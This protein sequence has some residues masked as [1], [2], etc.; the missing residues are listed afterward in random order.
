MNDIKWCICGQRATELHHIVFRSQCKPLEHCKLNQ[1]YLCQEHHR[2]TKGIHGKR[3]HKLDIKLKLEFQN[4]LEMLLDKQYLTR[5]DIQEVLQI[6]DKALNSLCKTIKCGKGKFI[7]E[8]VI[9][10]CMGGKL[11]LEGN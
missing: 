6:S 5:E 7:R 8:E 3:G 4:K 11:I 2:G 1:V 10:A 9:R